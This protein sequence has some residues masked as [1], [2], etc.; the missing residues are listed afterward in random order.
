MHLNPIWRT[1]FLWQLL[2]FL[3]LHICLGFRFI[4]S[5]KAI[6]LTRGERRERERDV[7]K[8]SPVPEGQMLILVN[9]V[10]PVA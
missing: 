10:I 6:V 1:T 3:A 5:K 4:K 8:Y 9:H 2:D 7:N